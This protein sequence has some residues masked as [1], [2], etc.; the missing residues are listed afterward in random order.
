MKNENKSQ[1]LMFTTALLCCEHNDGNQSRGTGMYYRFFDYN[2]DSNHLPVIIT[3]KHVVENA[4]KILININTLDSNGKFSPGNHIQQ[5]ITN[6]EFNII[7]HPD[8][9]VDLCAILLGPT[10]TNI[11][12]KGR[13]THIIALNHKS[14]L[15]DEELSQVT[16]VEEI[17]MIGYP[18]GLS[19][20]H[21]NLPIARKGITATPLFV[22]YN[23]RK[24]FLIDAPCFPG[25]SGSPVFLIK[26]NFKVEGNYLT[27]IANIKLLGNL[28]AGPQYEIDGKIITKT[29][30][31]SIQYFTRTEI[32]INLG[33]VIKAERI[34]EL[35]SFIDNNYK[36]P[37]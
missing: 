10:I 32:L 21:N 23:N 22:D 7:R 15:T 29:V 24:E 11:Q 27:T 8:P 36:L 34:M 20:I 18:T 37:K 2:E 3:N 35:E 14:I 26:K 5:E 4:V 31:T 25:S 28:Y 13:Q 33:N 12:Q 19:D 6:L 16:T 1:E 17:I 9:E 30:P